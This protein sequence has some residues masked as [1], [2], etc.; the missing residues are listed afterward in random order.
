MGSYF[1]M[2]AIISTMAPQES[3]PL[4]D[5]DRIDVITGDRGD[6]SRSSTSGEH[7]EARH[8]AFHTTH[9]S[10]VLAAA[11]PQSPQAREALETLGQLYWYPLYAYVRR[12][13]YPSDDAHDLTQAFF[14]TDVDYRTCTPRRPNHSSGP[15]RTMRPNR[16]RWTELSAFAGFNLDSRG[17]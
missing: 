2:D 6:V 11:D 13:G 5:G 3:N 1:C 10:L 16:P 7:D 8:R 15:R 14:P 12:K 4:R 17:Q 9:W